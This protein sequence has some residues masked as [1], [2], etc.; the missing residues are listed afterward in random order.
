LYLFAI[1]QQ[2]PKRMAIEGYLVARWQIFLK[3]QKPAIGQFPYWSK[4]NKCRIEPS[5]NPNAKLR[6]NASYPPISLLECRS[7][8]RFIQVFDKEKICWQKVTPSRSRGSETFIV[9]Y[10]KVFISFRST[11]QRND[12]LQTQGNV[13]MI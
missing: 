7:H 1:E 5:C 12:L 4:G 3:S 10:R 6:H 8:I 13:S 11:P 9:Q 2:V